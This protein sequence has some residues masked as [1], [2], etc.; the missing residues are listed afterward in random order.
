M[1][2]MMPYECEHG[3]TVDWGDFGPHQ[4]DEDCRRDYGRWPGD[5]A[6]CPTCYPT[7]PQCD[8]DEAIRWA[9]AVSRMRFVLD[10][11][12]RKVGHFKGGDPEAA[13][14]YVLEG[15]PS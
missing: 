4:S 15:E 7:C 13:L 8:A 6:P 12:P 9:A 3:V 10:R 2:R 11:V 14:L 1:S 5:G